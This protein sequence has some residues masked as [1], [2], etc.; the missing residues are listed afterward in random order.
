M[1][2]VA[3]V[4]IGYVNLKIFLNTVMKCTTEFK[5]KTMLVFKLLLTKAIPI[6]FI[7]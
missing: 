6:Q 5:L 7:T 3:R 1:S 2:L 4:I